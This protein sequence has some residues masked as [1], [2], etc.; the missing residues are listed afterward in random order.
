[1]RIASLPVTMSVPQK[2]VSRRVERS[3]TL[4]GSEEKPFH[5]TH[6]TRNVSGVSTS[7]VAQKTAG[8]EKKVVI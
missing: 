3:Q 8:N 6:N 7:T 2:A 1:V 5:Y 4:Q